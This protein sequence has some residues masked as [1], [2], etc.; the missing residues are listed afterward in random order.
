M[1]E[2]QDRV[3]IE[4]DCEHELL[5]ETENGTGHKCSRCG[6]FFPFPTGP[7]VEYASL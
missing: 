3:F 2:P 4:D 5:V 6:I 1:R 7:E